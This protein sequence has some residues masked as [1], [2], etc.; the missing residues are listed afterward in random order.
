MAEAAGAHIIE[1]TIVYHGHE[2][3]VNYG[4]DAG[5]LSTLQA[6]N[7]RILLEK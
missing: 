2:F 3:I 5:W 1:G 6:S 4:F 7:P